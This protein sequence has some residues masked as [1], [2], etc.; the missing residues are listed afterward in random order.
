MLQ[1]CAQ[2]TTNIIGTIHIHDLPKEAVSRF[3][4]LA[5]RSS[6]AHIA[7]ALPHVQK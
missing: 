4:S 7:G 3:L 5:F 2:H 6:T 1:C